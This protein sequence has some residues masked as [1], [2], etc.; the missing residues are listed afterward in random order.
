MCIAQ[1]VAPPGLQQSDMNCTTNTATFGATRP[2]GYAWGWKTNGFSP[3]R[4]TNSFPG[5]LI[6]RKRWSSCERPP[7]LLNEA[8]GFSYECTV[9]E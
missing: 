2:F 3:K 8:N 7:D 9:Q 6:G 4:K 5:S 1:E